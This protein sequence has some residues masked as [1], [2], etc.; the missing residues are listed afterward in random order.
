M[1]D[2][3]TPG[4]GLDD[5]AAWPHDDEA[6]IAELTAFAW[7]EVEARST[8]TPESFG[9]S[10]TIANEVPV[11]VLAALLGG[12]VVPDSE[13]AV[14][15]MQ[16]R[17]RVVAHHQAGLLEAMNA[18]LDEYAWRDDDPQLAME[19]AVAEVRAALSLTRRAAESDLD[20]AWRMRDCLPEVL[21][22]LRQGRIDLRRAWVIVNGT[23]HLDP[24][25][26]R[27]VASQVLGLADGRTTAQLKSVLRRMC[28]EIDPAES[29]RRFESALAE[30]RVVAEFGEES[31][32]TLIASNLP[33]ERVAAIMDRLTGIAH[34]LR[35]PG[36][37]RTIDQ[38]RS[39]IALDLLQGTT[40]S[41]VRGTIDIR[42]D[43]ATLVGLEERPAEL[44]GWGPVVADVARQM[45]L[46]RGPSWRVTVTDAS[47][48]FVHSALT[49]RRPDASLRR[50]VEAR[51]ATCVFPGCRHPAS[52]CDLD[53]RVRVADGGETHFDQLV[54]L[55]RHDHVVRH[56]HGWSHLRREDGSHIWTS[57]LGRRYTRPP[58][59]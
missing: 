19:G 25:D 22:A 17:A 30:R 28:M 41:D 4:P 29:V 27:R 9:S 35:G 14:A 47:D 18:V 24:A 43:L 46:R 2:M 15:V 16:V 13:G 42:V 58:P 33:P 36:E 50:Q 6:L 5:P 56:R 10:G 31:T 38:L 34:T 45:T 12:P 57:P 39:D 51:D 11:E 40:A 48:Q 20:L 59:A 44:G 55:C 3:S 52:S 21:G 26:A 32:A 54:P 1:F 49:R 8:D 23:S 7:A 53:H 37:S